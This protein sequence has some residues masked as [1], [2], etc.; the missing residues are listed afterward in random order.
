MLRGDS[1]LDTKKVIG[2]CT[3]EGVEFSLAVSRNKRIS[4]AIEAVDESAYTPA[5]CPGAV[6]LSPVCDQLRAAHR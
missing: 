1:A 4:A 5:H 2:V 3:E 6:A